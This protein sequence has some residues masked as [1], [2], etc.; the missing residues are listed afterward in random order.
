MS[1]NANAIAPVAYLYTT[2]EEW[3]SAGIE[4]ARPHFEA[5]GA[6]IPD[7]LRVSVSS[8]SVNGRK[9]SAKIAGECWYP[10]A[11]SDGH[12]EIFITADNSDDA[13]VF[14]V[15]VHELVHA[16][17]YPEMGH[18]KSFKALATAL[19]LKGKMTATYGGEEFFQ[20]A[21]PI[22]SDLGPMPYAAID[23]TAPPRK[24]KP[25]YVIGHLCDDCGARCGITQTN[26]DLC[27]GEVRCIN[28]H[29]D[30]TMHATTGANAE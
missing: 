14:D 9:K 29:C 28:P 5:L 2:R 13:R 30:G 6:T 10:A 26:L 18:G 4:A 7:N 11:S 20:W 1:I 27:G 23:Y 22:L 12:F 15:L 19:G 3:L 16:A 25:T 8:P 17:C 24:K 21:N